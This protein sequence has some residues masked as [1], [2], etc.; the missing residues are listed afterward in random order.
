MKQNNT[1]LSAK[2]KKTIV[3]YLNGTEILKG[4]EDND[5][6]A[7]ELARGRQLV[8]RGIDV[9]EVGSQ[10]ATLP[11]LCLGV[12]CMTA[13]RKH[14]IAGHH[15]RSEERRVGKECRSRWSPYH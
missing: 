13:A 8:Y 7:I 5:T 3:E 2:D 12:D 14:W 10:L 4:Q 6:Q 1:A 11:K 15:R 9:V